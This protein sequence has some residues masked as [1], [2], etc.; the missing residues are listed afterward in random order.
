MKAGS[1]AHRTDVDDQHPTSS[2]PWCRHR[3]ER[4][5]IAP[6][7][8]GSSTGYCSRCYASILESSSTVVYFPDSTDLDLSIP[9]EYLRDIL[10]VTGLRA[11]NKTIPITAA[12]PNSD[13]PQR[14]LSSI[15]RTTA[16]PHPNPSMSAT[17]RFPVAFLFQSC[18]PI[19]AAFGPKYTPTIA[20]FVFA[21]FGSSPSLP[22]RYATL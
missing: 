4:A 6:L 16:S 1:A 22:R 15:A 18:I 14:L 8:E 17:N 2:K 3:S 21:Q 19:T 12:D 20:S 13:H 9:S 11:N 5:A 7:S 10:D